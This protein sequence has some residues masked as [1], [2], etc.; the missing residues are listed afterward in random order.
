MRLAHRTVA[1]R[2]DEGVDLTEWQRWWR[3]DGFGRLQG[4]LNEKWDPIGSAP[5]DEYDEVVLQLGRK[6]REGASAA[7][8]AAYLD[9][10]EAAL[11][12]VSQVEKNRE[13][14]RLV[15]A[16]Y[17]SETGE[18]SRTRWEAIEWALLGEANRGWRRQSHGCFRPGATDG[19]GALRA[20]VAR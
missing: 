3:S 7:E 2:Q 5:D 19:A 13:A 4:L 16:W 6:V 12:G 14:A 10:A 8:V 18:P 11:I 9:S 1:F 15:K 17:S 20:P